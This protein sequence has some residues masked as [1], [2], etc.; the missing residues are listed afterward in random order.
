MLAPFTPLLKGSVLFLMCTVLLM[1]LSCGAPVKQEDLYGQWNYLEV[2]NPEQG[3]ASKSDP[4]EIKE[5]EPSICFYNNGDL[6]MNWGGKVLSKG[7]FALEYPDIAYVEHLEG[8]KTRKIRFL[9]KKMA[10][11]TLVFQTQD[12]DPVR[13]VAVKNAR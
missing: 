2:S 13:V 3:P 10:A 5:K 8:G 1:V 11:D 9:I 7:T 6:V 12:A 4:S